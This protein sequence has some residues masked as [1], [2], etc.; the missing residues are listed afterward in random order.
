MQM[1]KASNQ[2]QDIYRRA[3][4]LFRELWNGEP[5]RLLGI[6]T[7]KLSEES[8]PEQL[9]LFDMKFESEETRKKKKNLKEALKKL[10]GKYGDGIVKKGW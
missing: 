5:I 8:E 6:R 1:E 10:E 4:E 3:V 7:S 2:D 9:S